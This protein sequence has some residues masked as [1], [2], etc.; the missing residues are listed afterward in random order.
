MEMFRDTGI[1]KVPAVN[2][3]IN[4]LLEAGV[5]KFLVFAHH[6]AVMEAI[7]RNLINHKVDHIRIDGKTPPHLR[8][9]MVN[10]FQTSDDCKVAILGMTAAGMGLT[11]TKASL[12]IFAEL[13]WNPGI[14]FQCEDRA[15]RI[16]QKSF[17]TIKYLIGRGTIDEK[18]WDLIQHKLSVLGQVLNGNDADELEAESKEDYKLETR[19]ESM[20]DFLNHILE[21]VDT[22]EERFEERRER[23]K[24]KKDRKLYGKAEGDIDSDEYD[25]ESEN[26]NVESENYDYENEA[27]ND[28]NENNNNN[29]NEND[30]DFEPTLTLVPPK[31]KQ[32]PEQLATPKTHQHP[33]QS[34][35]S[36]KKKKKK[37]KRR[38]KKQVRK[39]PR[40]PRVHFSPREDRFLL[41]SKKTLQTR[42]KKFTTMKMERKKN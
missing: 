15:H 1:S 19:K 8:H 27:Q 18:I 26:G 13:Y 23:R 4:D 29:N 30:D 25:F 3:Y 16:G 17:V 20:D 24:R 33:K 9:E 36:K 6:Q 41:M 10:T 40:S 7:E 21:E 2:D 35:R 42:M 34:D 39:N 28:Q 32:R 14:L 37:K 38:K 5:S 22:F 31:K 11:L 12:V